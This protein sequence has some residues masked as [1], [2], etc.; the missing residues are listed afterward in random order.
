MIYDGIASDI[1]TAVLGYLL[2]GLFYWILSLIKIKAFYYIAIFSIAIYIIRGAM[3]VIEETL[4]VDT[5]I[6]NVGVNSYYG[7]YYSLLL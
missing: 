6:V 2:N 3:Q 7:Y 5:Y 1:G 4:A